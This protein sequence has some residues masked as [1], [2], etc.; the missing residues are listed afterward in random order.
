MSKLSEIFDSTSPLLVIIGENEED[1][2]QV[3]ELALSHVES[4]VIVWPSLEDVSDELLYRSEGKS[5]DTKTLLATAVIEENNHG[6][7]DFV[8]MDNIATQGNDYG[9]SAVIGLITSKDVND[10][11]AHSAGMEKFAL[12]KAV[13]VDSEYARTYLGK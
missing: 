13:V 7:L 3:T 11:I 4:D 2:A 6:K 12:S 10:V 8:H 5:L 9:V 1:V